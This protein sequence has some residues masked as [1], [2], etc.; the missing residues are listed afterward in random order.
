MDRE[1]TIEEAQF[2]VSPINVPLIK[3]RESG[4]SSNSRF[5]KYTAPSLR[6]LTFA[7]CVKPLLHL[8]PYSVKFLLKQSFFLNIE[9][10]PAELNV[11]AQSFFKDLTQL[12]P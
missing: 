11:E 9:I 3:T 1:T 10:H 4:E 5:Y 6:S 2:L 7:S 8:S 12:P